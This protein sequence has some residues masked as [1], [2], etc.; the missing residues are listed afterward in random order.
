MLLSRQEV[1]LQFPDIPLR[2]LWFEVVD[3]SPDDASWSNDWGFYGFLN[4]EMAYNSGNIASNMRG[5]YKAASEW[6][7]GEIEK[8]QKAQLERLHSKTMRKLRE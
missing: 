8:H 3:F 2:G 7:R 5:A 6:K 4:G 1:A